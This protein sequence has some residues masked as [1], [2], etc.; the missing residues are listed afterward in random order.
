MAAFPPIAQA[1]ERSW[2]VG[3]G[4]IHHACL[5]C[6]DYRSVY[7]ALNHP[8]PRKNILVPQVE[9]DEPEHAAKKQRS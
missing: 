8:R 1:K 4:K 9:E 7:R 5:W 2:T 6:R 3:E